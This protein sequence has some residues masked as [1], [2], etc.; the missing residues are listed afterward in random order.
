MVHYF[1][2]TIQEGNIKEIPNLEIYCWVN[3]IDPL[4][5]EKEK[6]YLKLC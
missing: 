2:R 3:D 1:K 4:P 5:Q 6:S